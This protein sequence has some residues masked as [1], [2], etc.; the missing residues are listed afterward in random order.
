VPFLGRHQIDPKVRAKHEEHHR[1]KL[2][3]ALLNP[4][5]T[6]EQRDSIQRQLTP[7]TPPSLAAARAQYVPAPPP[8]EKPLTQETSEDNS[9][10][11]S[12]DLTKLKKKELIALAEKLG[13]PTNGDRIQLIQRL[14]EKRGES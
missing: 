3:E 2:K 8:V 1:A 10:P 12:A 6:E 13:L 5:L 9:L 7:S 4:H 11:P 14:S